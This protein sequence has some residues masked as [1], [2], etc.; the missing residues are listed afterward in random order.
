VL[1]AAGG[2]VTACGDA[3]GR[4]GKGGWVEASWTGADTGR[5]GAHG[6]AEWCGERRAL[7]IRG[8]QGDT[9]LA[10]LVYPVDSIEPD[11]FRVVQP[12]GADTMVPAGAIVLRVF[13]A[14]GVQGYQGDSGAIVLQR[15]ESGELSGTIG[16]RVRSVV[17]GEQ[18]RLTGQL[19]GLPV[20]PQVR[21]CGP[22][23]PPADSADT[24]AGP[25]GT[26][27]D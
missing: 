22:A 10:V 1:L 20:V 4:S 7:E 2:L 19:R 11:T 26:D 27:V 13:Q 17:N 9:G 21:G 12:E 15:S 16:A 23:A 14:N 18:L 8:V 24:N 5:M 25:I 6:T 3:A